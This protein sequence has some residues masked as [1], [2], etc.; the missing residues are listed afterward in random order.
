MHLREA[1]MDWDSPAGELVVVVEEMHV[2]KASP[3]RKPKDREQQVEGWMTQYALL[4]LDD[5]LE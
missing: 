4:L 3:P 2:S 1:G 5:C